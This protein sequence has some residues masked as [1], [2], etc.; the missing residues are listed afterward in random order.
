M[1]ERNQGHCHHFDYYGAILNLVIVVYLLLALC[2]F[3]LGYSVQ[4]QELKFQ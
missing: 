1:S 4:T 3:M 2:H